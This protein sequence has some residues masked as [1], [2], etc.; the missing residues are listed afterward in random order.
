MKRAIAQRTRRGS[1]PL[2]RQ[3]AALRVVQ[4]TF[5]GMAVATGFLAV[6]AWE[7]RD[8]PLQL[9]FLATASLGLLIAAIAMGLRT[10]RGPRPPHLD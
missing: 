2:P 7:S 4:L 10:I 8:P 3:R 6:Q 9:I 5:V 1:P